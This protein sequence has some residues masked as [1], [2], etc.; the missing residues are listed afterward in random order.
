MAAPVA[1]GSSAALT[2]R[3]RLTSVNSSSRIRPARATSSAAEARAAPQASQRSCWRSVPRA[4]RNRSISD[5]AATT[6]ATS[7]TRPATQS[8]SMWPSRAGTASGLPTSG[9]SGRSGA[10]STTDPSSHNSAAAAATRA[11]QR[12]RGDGS[13]PVGVSSSTKP[14]QEIQARPRPL[15][16]PAR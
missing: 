6:S 14:A 4:R 9:N 2:P 5:P 10:G 16:S 12:Q 15:L 7:T 8:Q 1:S 3:A 11:H 13:R